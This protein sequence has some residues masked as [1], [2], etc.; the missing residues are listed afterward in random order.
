[1]STTQAIHKDAEGRM[2][3]MILLLLP[4]LML[5]IITLSNRNYAQSL[6]DNPGLLL[7]MFAAEVVGALWIRGIVNFD[8]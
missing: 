2:Q 1:M 4:P 3:A 7:G 8:F 5:L 6:L